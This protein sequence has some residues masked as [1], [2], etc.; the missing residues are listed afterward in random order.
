MWKPFISHRQAAAVRITQ[1]CPK[2]SPKHISMPPSCWA[3]HN[4]GDY[5]CEQS[6]DFSRLNRQEKLQPLLPSGKVLKPEHHVQSTNPHKVSPVLLPAGGIP[7]LW[8]ITAPFP[9]KG[10]W[11]LQEFSAVLSLSFG[12]SP[13]AS[14]AC[15][16]LLPCR[17]LP[18]CPRS[19]GWI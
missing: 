3:P 2:S 19:M 6:T 9:R 4:T 18:I 11:E 10:M 7:S 17:E 8:G 13:A 16:M 5:E 14:P 1:M 15:V 12:E